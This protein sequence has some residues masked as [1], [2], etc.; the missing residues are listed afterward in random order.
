M[1]F[2]KK[3]R[4][5]FLERNQLMIGII[6]SALVIAGSGTAILLSGGVFAKTYTVE[7]R[8]VDAAGLKG[9]DKVRVAGLEAGKVSGVTIEDGAVTVTLDVNQDIEMPADSTAEITIETLLGRKTVTLFAGSSNELLADGDVIGLEDTRTPVELLDLANTSVRLLEESD[10]DALETFM[11]EITKVTV[12]KRTQVS[13]LISGLGDVMEAVDIRRDELGRLLDSLHT[14]SAT[15]A[16]RDDTLVSLI[17]NYDVILANLATRTD[18]LQE[19]L[20]STDSAS[21]EV[22]SLVRRNRGRIDSALNGLRVT[23]DTLDRNQLELAAAI[24]YLEQ[25]V[26]GYQSIGWSQGTENRWANIFVQ[27]L[28]PVGIDAI[29]GPCGALDQALDDLLG[30]DPRDCDER[31]EFGEEEPEEP[32]V[33]GKDISDPTPDADGLTDTIQDLLPGDL[34]DLLDSITGTFGLGAALRG[35][36]LP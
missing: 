15:F 10:A 31:A 19:L 3:D 24:P 1:K 13:Q 2:F 26:R 6:A 35:G 5:S 34:G 25:A 29:A 23:L 12:G 36:L 20:E 18:D 8:F 17:D 14:L 9:G 27:S 33:P 7:A 28:G 22:A 30:P 21:S 11:E 4:G 32:P 16:E